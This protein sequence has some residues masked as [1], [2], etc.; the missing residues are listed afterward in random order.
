MLNIGNAHL[1]FRVNC[2]FCRLSSDCDDELIEFTGTGARFDLT[3]F[4]SVENETAFFGDRNEEFPEVSFGGAS[5]ALA[6]LMAAANE[7]ELCEN[8]KKCNFQ[9]FSSH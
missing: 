4:I 7:A 2:S 5:L 6:E 1:N 9:L 8:T 3:W